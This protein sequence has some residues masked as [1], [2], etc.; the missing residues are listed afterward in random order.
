MQRVI[1][2]TKLGVQLYDENGNTIA[3]PL[4]SLDALGKSI[5]DLTETFNLVSVSFK[6]IIVPLVFGETESENLNEDPI[7]ISE[8]LN[9]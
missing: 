9:T 1:Y 4:D 5:D 6:D 3:I 7:D 8:F 2:A